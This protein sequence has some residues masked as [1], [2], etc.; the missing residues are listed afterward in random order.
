MHI[1]SSRSFNLGT[2]AFAALLLDAMVMGTSV[3]AEVRVVNNPAYD[4]SLSLST[5][6]LPVRG[7]A[8]RE[9][10]ATVGFLPTTVNNREGYLQ[11][12]FLN[13][14][15]TR[16][17][18]NQ[19]QFLDQNGNVIPRAVLGAQDH[20]YPAAAFSQPV[21]VRM[22]TGDTREV[23]TLET[24]RSEHL[25]TLVPGGTVRPPRDDFLNSLAGGNSTQQ[26]QQ[27]SG[28]GTRP[29]A[30]A[31]G[32]G[33]GGAAAPAGGGSTGGL[34]PCGQGGPCQL[35]QI[36]ELGRNIFNF[37]LGLGAVAAVAAIVV[38]GFRYMTAHGDPGSLAEA[39][40]IVTWAIIGLVILLLAFVI[41]NT[42]LNALG[43][44]GQY[45]Q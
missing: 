14:A 17:P 9:Y 35:E 24:L 4:V 11:A 13:A 6:Q 25:G 1:L 34:V 30:S 45:R 22:F 12:E 7:T 39:K 41:V 8:P 26:N 19:F 42:I 40:Q 21:A 5:G 18:P 43:V 28:A 15:G 2:V 36:K 23:V 44:L 16:L 10:A 37:L 3:H 27:G 32:G 38:G 29:D 33:G 31:G 20:L